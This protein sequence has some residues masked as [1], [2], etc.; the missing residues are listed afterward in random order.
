MDRTKDSV[1]NRI[2]EMDAH[3]DEEEEHRRSIQSGH[4]HTHNWHR[5]HT[6][7]AAVLVVV[8]EEDHA[9]EVEVAAGVEHRPFA[10]V[11]VEFVVVAA[12]AEVQHPF[13][14]AVVAGE[15]GWEAIAVVVA[16]AVETIEH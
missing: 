8:V 14:A 16:V 1:D 12:A 6:S 9:Y 2:V 11:G 4:H 10:V 15:V 3:E 7:V 13:A 5:W